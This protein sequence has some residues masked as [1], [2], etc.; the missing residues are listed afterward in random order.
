[1]A[2]KDLAL[3]NWHIILCDGESCQKLGASACIDAIRDHITVRGLDAQVHTTRT[4]CNGRCGD[5]PVAIV[6]PDGTWYQRLTSESV[7]RVVDEHIVL[8]VP[9]K[10]NFLHQLSNRSID[11]RATAVAEGGDAASAT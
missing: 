1:V 4:K 5:G 3:V 2:I 6:Y 9:V 11:N 7:R 8:G 10:A